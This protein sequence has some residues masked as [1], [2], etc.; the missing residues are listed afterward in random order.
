MSFEG[1]VREWA[2]EN[3]REPVDGWEMYI[4]DLL[5]SEV[6]PNAL[7]SDEIVDAVRGFLEKL[8]DDP[9][10]HGVT[11]PIYHWDSQKIYDRNDVEGSVLWNF[12][13]LAEFAEGHD[14]IS[15][16]IHSAAVYYVDSEARNAAYELTEA[17]DDLEE[18]LG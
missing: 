17:L 15:D 18:R 14:T 5:V 8:N 1:I 6:S 7:E 9:E 16:L 11:L 4:P 13:S 12:G 3:Y 10:Y 2:N